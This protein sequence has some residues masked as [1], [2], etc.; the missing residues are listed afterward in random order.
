MQWVDWL[1][2]CTSVHLKQKHKCMIVHAIYGCV[3]VNYTY[4]YIYNIMHIYI[5]L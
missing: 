2:Y 4:M 5:M 3:C 1:L